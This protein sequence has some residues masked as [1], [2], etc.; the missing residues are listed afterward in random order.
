MRD[1][2]RA[3]TALNAS[4]I[5]ADPTM[6]HRKRRTL[7][8]ALLGAVLFPALVAAVLPN[9]SAEDTVFVAAEVDP[10][11]T[12]SDEATSTTPAPTTTAAPTTVAPQST[13]TT[14]KPKSTTTTAKPKPV[15]TTTAPKAVAKAASMPAPVA[16]AAPAGSGATAEEAAFLACVRRRES[17]GNYGV[18]S[19]NGLWYGAYQMTR[20]TWDSAAQ[21]AGRPDLVGVPPNQASPGDQDY[22]ALV[23]Y[24]WLGKSPWGGA[25]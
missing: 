6:L 13:A 23:L 10:T 25:C 16:A 12:P 8:L 1:D 4:V 21:R 18:V 17:G 15:P 22:L 19:S 9:A 20:Q 14:A 2:H 11:T 7:F 5:P 24:R 3:T